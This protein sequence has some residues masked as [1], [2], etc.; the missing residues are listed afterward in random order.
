MPE[1]EPNFLQE[2]RLKSTLLVNVRV[3]RPGRSQQVY[4]GSK[5]RAYV[6]LTA[7]GGKSTLEFPGLIQTNK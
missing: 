3:G 5:Y 4:V 2:F 6:V 7:F 1:F